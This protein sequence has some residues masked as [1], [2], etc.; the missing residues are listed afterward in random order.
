MSKTK[1]SWLV[2]GL[3]LLALVLDQVSK[4]YIK[5]H[6]QVGEVREVFSWFHIVFV[7]NDGM[8]VGIA[9]YS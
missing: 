8:A 9:W 5:T 4:V 1:Q 3:V 2:L 7:E 6:F